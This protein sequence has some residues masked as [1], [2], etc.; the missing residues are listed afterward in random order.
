MT[1][2]L[3]YDREGRPLDDPMKWAKLFSDPKYKVLQKTE[4]RG[5]VVS[6]VWLGLDHG[7]GEGPPIIFETIVFGGRCD[8]EMWRYST[9]EQARLGHWNAVVMVGRPWWLRAV[10]WLFPTL[11]RK[12]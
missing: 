5:A 6:T 9:E 7:W 11:Y 8:G 2:P 4:T 1:F 3:Y 12:E 10:M